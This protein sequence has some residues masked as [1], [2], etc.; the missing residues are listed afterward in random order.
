MRKS[1]LTVFVL[2]TFFAHGQNKAIFIIIDGIPAD[3]IEKVE[4][5]YLDEI[6]K[7]GGYTRAYIGGEK[8]GYSQSPT[9]SAVGYNHVLTGTW[10]NKHNVW[11]ND[12]KEPNYQYWNIF[13][14]AKQA[15]P[16]I[17]TGIFSTW[18]DTGLPQAGNLQLDYVFDGY[19]NDTVRFPHDKDKK[20]ILGID[21]LVSGEAA[22]TIR[23][24]APDLSWVYMEYTDDMGHRYGDSPQFYDA[25]KLAD[26]Q[27]GKIWKALQHREATTKEKWMVVITT[28][29][30]R[31]AAT[32][33]GHGGQSDRERSV[34]ITTN[35]KPLNARFQHQPATVDIMPSLLR[36]MNIDIPSGQRQE[37]DGV[38][39]VGPVSIAN[40]KAAVTN[41]QLTLSWDVLDGQGEVEIFATT[42]NHF[43]SGGTDTYQLLGKTKAADGRV[44]VSVTTLPSSFY[45]IRAKA[46]HNEVNTWVVK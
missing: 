24:Q 20:Y 32:G 14:L 9:I 21:E 43:K 38:P 17:K 6:A 27:I 19:E 3:V 45:K 39:F 2:W 16:N 37:L 7:Q 25:V 33:K 34:W 1:I 11:D 12:I 35:Y 18:L 26:A 42:T 23:T 22:T 5:P 10:T 40:L 30:G 8:G 44:V 28:D 4:T 15:N 36:F 13:R 41:Q 46:Q 29:H 31:E